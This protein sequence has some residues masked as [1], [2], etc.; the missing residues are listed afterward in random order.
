MKIYIV[1]SVASGKTTYGKRLSEILKVSCTHLDGLVHQKDPSNRK[2][3]NIRRSDAEIQRLFLQVMQEEAW[4]VEDAGRPI[5]EYAL[6]EAD[7]ILWLDPPTP[8]RAYRILKRYI[9]QKL[10]IEVCLYTPNLRMLRF[11][12]KWMLSYSLNRDGLRERVLAYE[13][14]VIRIKNRHELDIW[15]CHL[16]KEHGR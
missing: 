2:W 8:V 13:E 10:K 14:K 6:A 12:F 3:G 15:T 4:L 7:Y 5:F 16:V 9:K 11:M 1:G